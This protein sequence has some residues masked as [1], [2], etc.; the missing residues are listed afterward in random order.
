MQARPI[1]HVQMCTTCASMDLSIPAHQHQMQRTCERRCNFDATAESTA[2]QQR[3]LLVVG[4][5]VPSLVCVR[6]ATG[7]G[8]CSD[9]QYVQYVRQQPVPRRSSAFIWDLG[10][11]RALP[12]NFGPSD[13]S[14]VTERQHLY[15]LHTFR[16]SRIV[17][18]SVSGADFH[19][20][21]L[22]HACIGANRRIEGSSE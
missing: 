4:S 13:W 22:K 1:R 6:T 19:H 8:R 5:L 3:C 16:N 7:T 14:V 11:C 2:M 9:R 21:L 20:R 18:Y 10:P 12:A 15:T 17:A